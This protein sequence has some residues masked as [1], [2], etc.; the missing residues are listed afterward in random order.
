MADHG[1]DPALRTGNQTIANTT[2]VLAGVR[3]VIAL[4]MMI[5]AE[6]L[7]LAE[8]VELALAAHRR[9]LEFNP[10]TKLRT[11]MAALAPERAV[12]VARG[13]EREGRTGRRSGPRRRR[14]SS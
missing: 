13:V 14:V 11:R 6:E 9:S 3:R 4:T 5:L 12:T 2:C 8:V 10:S 7:V 1:P